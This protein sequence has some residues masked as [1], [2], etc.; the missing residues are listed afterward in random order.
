MCGF[1]LWRLSQMSF[2]RWLLAALGQVVFT[3]ARLPCIQFHWGTLIGSGTHPLLAPIPT[4]R[5][6]E[7]RS[8]RL[9]SALSC[10]HRLGVGRPRL[11]DWWSHQNHAGWTKDH[12]PQTQ[13]TFTKM[14]QV[15]ISSPHNYYWSLISFCIKTCLA[16]ISS[17]LLLS[18]YLR[19]ELDVNG[20]LITWHGKSFY[21]RP[22][23]CLRSNP[24]DFD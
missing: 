11:C 6:W 14:V 23:T 2:K 15:S 13:H 3:G 17:F 5:H 1:I 16:W 19:K 7:L 24:G 21:W 18:F 12:S 22:D 9:V 10:T 8:A 20:P 4:N